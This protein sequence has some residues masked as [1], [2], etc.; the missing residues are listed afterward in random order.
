MKSSEKQFVDTNI[1]IYTLFKV[2]SAKHQACIG[3]F[4]EAAQGKVKL[5]TTQWVIA[6]LMWFLTR[7]RMSWE[8]IRSVVEKIIQTRGLEVADKDVFFEVMKECESGEDFVDGINVVLSRR[9]NI[10]KGYSY[11]KGL[12]KWQGFRRMEP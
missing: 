3:L 6:E 4:E 11:D 8:E 5:W 12:G 1:F 7:K 2:D 10:Y 9:E